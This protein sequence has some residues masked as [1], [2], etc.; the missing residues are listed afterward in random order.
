[1]KRRLLWVALLALVFSFLVLSPVLTTGYMSDDARF[2]LERGRLE[3]TGETR[4]QYYGRLLRSGLSFKGEGARFYPLVF[5]FYHLMS[6]M[7]RGYADLTSYKLVI[8][9]LV[10]TNVLLLGHLVAFLSGS[11]SLGVMALLVPLPLM[12]HGLWH[13][14]MSFRGLMPL[15]GLYTLGS[16]TL[17]AHHVKS[18]RLLPYAGSLLLYAVSLATYEITCTLSLLHLGLVWAVGWRARRLRRVVLPFLVLSALLVVATVA[19]RLVREVPITTAGDPVSTGRQSNIP[20]VNPKAYLA[21]L[22][23]HLYAALPLSYYASDPHGIFRGPRAD[24]TGGGI[25]CAAVVAVGSLTLLTMAAFGGGGPAATPRAPTVRALWVLGG[26][27]LLLSPALVSLSPVYQARVEWGTAYIPVYLSRLG[28][29][30][31]VAGLLGLTLREGTQTARAGTIVLCA[32][33][34]IASGVNYRNN[35]SVIRRLNSIWL[36]P[37]SLIADALHRGLLRS[38]GDGASLVVVSGHHWEVT[39]PQWRGPHSFYQMH[40][41]VSLGHVSAEALFPPRL[42][43]GRTLTSEGGTTA[44]RYGPEDELYILRYEALGKGHG[45]ALLG[46]I[47]SVRVFEDRVEAAWCD[48]AELYVSAGTKTQALP[49]AVEAAGMDAD[50]ATLGHQT[51]P[52]GR[53]KLRNSGPGWR[54]YSLVPNGILLEVMS[55]N[56][57]EYPFGR[58][59]RAPTVRGS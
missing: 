50:G 30:L 28:L 26:G 51:V 38:V 15:I 39:P 20:N 3:L 13:D 43:R 42:Y 1:M 9:A 52:A 5:P 19:G 53:M 41:G 35:R 49:V 44:A 10:L 47:R 37:R 46:H 32:A 7:T 18:G 48:H 29:A 6:W 17:L 36:H 31:L 25:A 54:L 45:Y 16:L 23:K 12:Q 2:S 22:G 57:G 4:G 11:R 59:W 34:A 8:L 55:A 24:E 58:A 56:V 33:L 14:P 27:L 40:S 21:T